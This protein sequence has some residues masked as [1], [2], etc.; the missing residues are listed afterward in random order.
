MNVVI[1]MVDGQPYL[2]DFAYH[3]IAR[4]VNGSVGYWKPEGLLELVDRLNA[5]PQIASSYIGLSLLKIAGKALLWNKA[6]AD[7]LRAYRNHEHE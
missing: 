3:Q 5:Q 1:P 6:S 4:V 7:R 2:L